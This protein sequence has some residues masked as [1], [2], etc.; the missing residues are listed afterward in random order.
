MIRLRGDLI[1][2]YKYLTGEN[3]DE[4]TR[5]FPVVPSDTVQ[6]NGHK[7]KHRKFLLNTSKHH[8][9]ARV[10][11]HWQRLHREGVESPSLEIM[12]SHLHM[13]LGNCSGWPCLSRGLA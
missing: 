5:L 13:V 10:V 7:L 8:L 9:T 11:K 1:N 2:V 6:G 4:G 12:K 3:E